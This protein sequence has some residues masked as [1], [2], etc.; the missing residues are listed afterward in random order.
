[1]AAPARTL[2][3]SVSAAAQARAYVRR[4]LAGLGLDALATDACLAVSELVTNALIHTTGPVSVGV[5]P[6]ADGVRVEVGDCSPV[7]PAPG[8]LDR[9]AMSGRGLLLV[10]R[11]SAA[12]GAEPTADGKIVWFLVRPDHEPDHAALTAD[13]LLSMWDCDDEPAPRGADP[14]AARPVRV[15][16]LR[17]DLL[18]EVKARGEDIGREMALVV[19]QPHGRERELADLARQLNRLMHELAPLRTAIRAQALAA[20]ARGDREVDLELTGSPDDAARI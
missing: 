3:R 13:D 20:A 5:Q 8:L 6:V 7:L 18:V 17:T 19:N 4:E 12:W 14:A 11:V 10:S 9:A 15:P 16:G 2:D 1:M